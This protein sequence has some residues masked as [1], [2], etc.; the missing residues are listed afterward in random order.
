MARILVIDD[1]KFSRSRVAAPLVR[2]GHQIVEATDGEEGLAAVLSHK[3]DCI[4]TD[5]LMPVVDGHEFLRRLRAGGSTIPVV[6][7]TADVQSSSHSLCEELGISG[8]LNKPFRADV[9]LES[10]EKALAQTAG[11]AV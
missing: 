10:V 3:P 1:S 8:F 6:V 2:A 4:T 9:L 5:L 7:I 11:V